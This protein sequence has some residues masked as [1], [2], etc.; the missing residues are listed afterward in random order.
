MIPYP[1]LK[2][3]VCDFFHPQF[4]FQ[5]S[6]VKQLELG[7]LWNSD[8]CLVSWLEMH[9]CKQI[10]I[11]W[12]TILIEGGLHRRSHSIPLN[13][14]TVFAMTCTSVGKSFHWLITIIILMK[15][16]L[17]E[18]PLVTYLLIPFWRTIKDWR[19]Q[20]LPGFLV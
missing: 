20:V 3:N 10:S 6:M 14:L 13:A 5:T 12:K 19:C 9:F 4:I 11:C 18:F 8:D 16:F 15:C 2:G 1:A 17:S 7:S